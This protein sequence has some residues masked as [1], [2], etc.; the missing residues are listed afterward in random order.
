MTSTAD[1]SNDEIR[2]GG[3]VAGPDGWGAE[4]RAGPHVVAL[5]G[6]HGLAASLRA[7][8]SYA[9]SV[10]GVV[11]VGDDGGSSGRLRNELGVAAPGDVRRCISALAAQDSLLGRALEYRF[12]EGSLTGHPIGN[13]LLTGMTLAG[14][15]LQAAIDELCRLVGVKGS[16]HPATTVPVRLLADSDRGTITGQVTIERATGI[17][18]LRF[19]PDDPPVA[20]AAVKAVVDADQVVLG[21]GSLYTSVLATAV[22]PGIRQALA[23][24]AGQRVF[25]ANV[26]N[27]KGISRGFGLA[28]HVE[29]VLD[30]G[31]AVDVVLAP[32]STPR[33][34]VSGIDVVWED[35]A[36]SDGWSHDPAKLGRAL[37]GLLVVG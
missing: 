10:T 17:H 18:N 19:D 30:H 23:D 2:G 15:D 20:D 29:A 7:V 8:S 4:D 25:V 36:G 6:G 13:L 21:P 26:A 22:V 28:E 9:G 11:S 27:E 16:I 24:T 37:R 34:V 35:L 14:G 12:A 32:S 1:G 33:T 3:A 31:V 5:G